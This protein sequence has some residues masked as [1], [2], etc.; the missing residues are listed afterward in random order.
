MCAVFQLPHDTKARVVSPAKGHGKGCKTTMEGT[1][2][3]LCW[4]LANIKKF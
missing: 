4:C 1:N 3:L 2:E